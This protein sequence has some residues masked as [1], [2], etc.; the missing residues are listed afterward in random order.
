MTSNPFPAICILGG[1][2]VLVGGIWWVYRP[3]AVIVA[4]LLL[5]ALGLLGRPAHKDR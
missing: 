5:L 3:G 1:A 4:G 2:L